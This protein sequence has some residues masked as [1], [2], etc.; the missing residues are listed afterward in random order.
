MIGKYKTDFLM[1]KVKNGD[2]KCQRL[3]QKP[4]VITETWKF[5][6]DKSLEPGK[7]NQ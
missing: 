3:L 5:I 6:S 1:G 7:I 2:V 4:K